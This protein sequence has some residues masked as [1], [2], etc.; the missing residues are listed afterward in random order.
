MIHN[1]T[2]NLQDIKK[3]LDLLNDKKYDISCNLY[4]LKYDIQKIKKVHYTN[5]IKIGI[6]KGTLMQI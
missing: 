5:K 1:T 4:D 6:L 2:C 3:E